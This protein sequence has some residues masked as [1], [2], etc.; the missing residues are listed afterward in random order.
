MGKMGQACA[1]TMAD[2]AV[3][4]KTGKDCKGRL[5]IPAVAAKVLT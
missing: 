5:A 1:P 4:M 3:K 2:S